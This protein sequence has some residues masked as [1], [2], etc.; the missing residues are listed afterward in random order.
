ML[1]LIPWRRRD[2][3]AY[4]ERSMPEFRREFDDLFDRFFNDVWG[5]DRGL[6]R[7]FA[8]AFDVSETDDEFI[9]R[10]EVPGVDPKDVDVNLSGNVLTIK[11]EKKD[12]REEKGENRHRIERSFGMFQRTFQ[13]PVEGDEEKISAKYK[14]G[15]LD[16]RLPKTEKGKRKSIKIDVA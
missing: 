14:D 9:V 12:E 7:T 5:T 13:I 15:V 10:A 3:E 1:S 16:L 2:V 6:A 8:P 11:G 4:P